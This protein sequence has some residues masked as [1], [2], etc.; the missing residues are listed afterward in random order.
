MFNTLLSAHHGDVQVFGLHANALV[1]KDLQD[2]K[3]LLDSLLLTQAQVG[4]GWGA[5]AAPRNR[6]ES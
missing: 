6:T 4:S 3:Q 2:T 1:T 5:D